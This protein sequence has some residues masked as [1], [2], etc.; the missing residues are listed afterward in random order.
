V[1]SAVAGYDRFMGRFAVPLASVF[2]DFAA[3]ERGRQVLDVGCGP[4]ALLT[5]LITR[6]GWK[7]AAGAEPSKDF[8]TAAR[9]RHPNV[10]I[11]EGSAERLPF[12]SESFDAALAQLVVHFM[13][14]PVAGLQPVRESWGSCSRRQAS[15]T[16]R[17]QRS[18][19]VSISTASTSGGRCS[20][21]ASH[22]PASTLRSSRW[23]SEKR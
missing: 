6:V 1:F 23:S 19:S 13:S 17:R 14:D 16:S 2:A 9:E 11:K 10:E 20:R 3:I 15:A 12:P 18:T 7:A 5:E 8:L 21:S 4:G 22:R